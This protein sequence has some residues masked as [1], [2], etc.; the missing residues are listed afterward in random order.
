MEERIRHTGHNFGTGFG[1]EVERWIDETIDGQQESQ[2]NE[3]YY[4][5]HT[6]GE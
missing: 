3:S 6:N 5:E 1:T 4:A 2:N